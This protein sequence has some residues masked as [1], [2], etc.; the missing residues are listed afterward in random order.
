VLVDLPLILKLFSNFRQRASKLETNCLARSSIVRLF[1]DTWFLNF[2]FTT[3]YRKLNKAEKSSRG[4]RVSSTPYIIYC[5]FSPTYENLR[6]FSWFVFYLLT[7]LLK[8]RNF[9]YTKTLA[10]GKNR[11]ENEI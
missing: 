10:T 7:L 1:F 4:T 9:Y 5:C 11:I 6:G 8:H 2:I 3:S